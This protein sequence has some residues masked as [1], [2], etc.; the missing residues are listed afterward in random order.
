VDSIVKEA[1]RQSDSVQVM[2]GPGFT[3]ELVAKQTDSFREAPVVPESDP[4]AVIDTAM[5]ETESFDPLRATPAYMLTAGQWEAKLYNQVYSQ[6]AYFDANRQAIDQ[7]ARSTYYS[8][9]FS[10]MFGLKARL[11]LGLEAWGQSVRFDAKDTSPLRVLFFDDIPGSRTAWTFLGP[12]VR[13]P[14]N[15]HMSLQSTFLVP[16]AKDPEGRFNGRPYLAS[17]NFIWWNQITFQSELS[18]HFQL[19]AQVDPYWN[20]KRNEGSGFFA[21]PTS[22]FLTYL[23]GTKFS[24]YAMSQF[25][26]QVLGTG[27]YA[28]W[29]QLGGGAKYA[30]F[31]RLTLELGYGRFLAGR[32]SAGP[33][34]ALNFGIRYIHW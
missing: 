19:F 8:G 16:L 28:W 5:L 9:I 1:P 18:T 7:G 26:P 15:R 24:L 2:P 29:W 27:Q 23:P 30:M 6:T 31:D 33:A 25:W 3:G 17:Q 20:I 32:N 4:L 10:L 22:A 11:N 34:T 21:L 14:L 13:L 12:K